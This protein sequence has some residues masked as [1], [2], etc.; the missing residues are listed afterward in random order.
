MPNMLITT[1]SITNIVQVDHMTRSCLLSPSAKSPSAAK[2][3]QANDSVYGYDCKRGAVN[4]TAHERTPTRRRHF[5][6][7][8]KKT[9]RPLC[10]IG[11][12]HH[13]G[14]PNMV[15]CLTE[16]ITKCREDDAFSLFLNNHCSI[17][18]QVSSAKILIVKEKTDV[19]TK[20]ACYICA[21]SLY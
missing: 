21:G 20:V 8:I 9:Q 12:H 17:H 14:A 2:L 6:V 4:S 11:V 3:D 19:P 13:G 10:K 15:G 16:F 18:Q 5:S 1:P 7:F